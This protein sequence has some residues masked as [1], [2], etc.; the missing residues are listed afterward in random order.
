MAHADLEL[1]VLLPQSPECLGL[2]VGSPTHPVEFPLH[3]LYS[4]QPFPVSKII[5]AQSE[6][7]QVSIRI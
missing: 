4:P 2:Q 5:L 6:K 1:Q 3:S 7:D